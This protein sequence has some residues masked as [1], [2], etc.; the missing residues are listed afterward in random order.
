MTF[1]GGMCVSRRTDHDGLDTA[2]VRSSDA[3]ICSTKVEKV[4]TPSRTHRGV[5]RN[6]STT[7]TL[8]VKTAAT[9][10]PAC[11]SEREIGRPDGRHSEQLPWAQCP[12]RA[13]DR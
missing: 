7:V 6:R 5:K 13:K 12:P 1:T 11:V 4:H 10:A 9:L 3:K 8:L 2:L